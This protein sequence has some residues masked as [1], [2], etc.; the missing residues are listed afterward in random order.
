MK[1]AQNKNTG[2]STE[3]M[4]SGKTFEHDPYNKSVCRTH[5]NG[6]STL[7]PPPP[8]QCAPTRHNEYAYSKDRWSSL[9]QTGHTISCGNHVGY[10]DTLSP[11]GNIA[12]MSTDS[13]ED[14]GN[15]KGHI[16]ESPKSMRRGLQNGQAVGIA[17][18][19]FE[20]EHS[21]GGHPRNAQ[22]IPPCYVAD[23]NEAVITNAN[24]AVLVDFNRI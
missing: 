18:Q 20:M 11:V 19:Y 10:H 1:R 17:P 21:V 6:A 3:L 8:P 15:Y 4:L 23:V 22:N 7:L 9:Q 5:N 12:D 13:E 14:G 16:Y 2:V 24:A